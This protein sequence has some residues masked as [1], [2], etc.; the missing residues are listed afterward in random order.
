MVLKVRAK[1][2][3]NPNSATQYITIPSDM[4]HDSQYP[5]NVGDTIDIEVV[6]ALKQIVVRPAP[7]R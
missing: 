2:G 3:G 4:V 5:L 1:V 7:K 6:P